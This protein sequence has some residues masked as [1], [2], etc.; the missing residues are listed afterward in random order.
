M[1][2]TLDPQMWVPEEK[3]Y[4]RC[5]DTVV[6]TAAGMENLTAAAPLELDETEELMR[7]R[8]ASLPFFP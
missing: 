4:I 5:E 1:V 8:A 6:V 3:L 2:F 7:T